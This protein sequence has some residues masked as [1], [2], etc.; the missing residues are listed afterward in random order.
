MVKIPKQLFKK[1]KIHF[2]NANSKSSH[3]LYCYYKEKE[4]RICWLSALCI[5]SSM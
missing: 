1:F 3:T 2:K 4:Q 5:P